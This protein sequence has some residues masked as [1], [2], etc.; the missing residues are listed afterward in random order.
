MKPV[1]MTYLQMSDRLHLSLSAKLSTRPE[2]SA[3]RSLGFSTVREERSVLEP[4]S[5]LQSSLIRPSPT[6]E[7]P[8]SRF[9]TYLTR[10]MQK[11]ELKTF[12]TSCEIS[13]HYAR[14][15][16]YDKGYIC[17]TLDAGMDRR[18]NVASRGNTP[19]KQS[20]NMKGQ[21]YKKNNTK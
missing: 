12:K 5:L 11:A 3:N 9:I 18:R 2:V 21:R 13:Y 4:I 20:G 8:I 15:I 7:I 19:A 17:L 1:Y 6:T 10:Q 16:S 14:I